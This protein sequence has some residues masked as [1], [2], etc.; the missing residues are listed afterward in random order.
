MWVFSIHNNRVGGKCTLTGRRAALTSS[1]ENIPRAPGN[2]PHDTPDS[3]AGDTPVPADYVW[4]GSQI[5]WA[6]DIAV[7]RPATGLWAVRGGDR[8]Y[9]GRTG[10]IPFAG[11]FTG[12]ALEGGGIY[13]REV[14]LWAI[15]GVTRAYFGSGNDIP[16]TR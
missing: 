3:A 16:V 7:F 4:Y 12:G 11:S 5:Q 6:A 14:G 15:R 9:F 1:A 13:R 8:A 2:K 10:D